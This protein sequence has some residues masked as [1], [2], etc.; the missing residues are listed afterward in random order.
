[1]QPLDLHRNKFRL[2]YRLPRDC[3][4]ASVRESR[5]RP[6]ILQDATPQPTMLKVAAWALF[7]SKLDA[8]PWGN[9]SVEITP[10]CQATPSALALTVIA[11]SGFV[12]Q[13]A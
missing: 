7:M 11:P 2:L 12:Q 3:Y 13:P 6:P 8:A 5:A 4:P 9:A 10:S 1:M